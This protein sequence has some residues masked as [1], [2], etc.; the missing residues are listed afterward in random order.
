MSILTAMVRNKERELSRIITAHTAALVR[1]QAAYAEP[2][3]NYLQA[4]QGSNVAV[5]AEVKRSSPSQGT[6]RADVDVAATAALYEA[7]GASAISVLTDSTYF[8]GSIDDLKTAR[9]ATKLPILRKDFTISPYQIYEARAAGADA[10]LL[11]VGALYPAML[12]RM[13]E[14]THELGMHALV[15]VHTADELNLALGS[16]AQLIGINNRDLT[17]LEVSLD[18]FAELAYRVPPDCILVSES[19]IHTEDDVRYVAQAGADAVL[20]GTCLMNASAPGDA[21]RNLTLTPR[22]SRQPVRN[23]RTTSDRLHNTLGAWDLS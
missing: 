12:K 20:V 11:I 8:G 16:G 9:E 14:T 17:T 1:E 19:G 21:V 13:L 22:T 6:I 2:P 23:S 15:E 3:E 10:I 4:L 5:I 18:T 7:N